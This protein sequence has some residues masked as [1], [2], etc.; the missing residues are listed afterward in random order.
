[1][2]KSLL[3]IL[4]VVAVSAVIPIKALEAAAKCESLSNLTLSNATI[5]TA[6]TIEAGQ[7]A[8]PARGN[9]QG[10]N[11]KDLPAFCRVMATV[12]PSNDSDI[13]IEV[14]L[15]VSGWNGKF[16]AVGN[17]GWAGVI[18]YPA[19]AEALTRGYATTSTDTGHTGANGAF[20]LGHPEKFVDFAWRSEHEMTTAGKAL[21]NAFYC[22]TPRYAFW[23]GCST[24]GRPGLAEAQRFPSDFT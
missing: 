5:T 16:Q 22:R 20:A 19:M 8:E 12:K 18:S 13:K 21:V 9:G 17:G 7:F 2:K 4:T 1:M 15:P 6:Q 14:W 24:G 23:N 3:L 11:F 10:P